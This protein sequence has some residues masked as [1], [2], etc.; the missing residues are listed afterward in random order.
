LRQLFIILAFIFPYSLLAQQDPQFSQYM[1]NPF[2]WNPSFSAL[3][4][5]Y[6][7]SAHH[8]SQWVGYSP[9]NSADKISPP[10]TQLFTF[11][12]PL[13]KMNSGAGFGLMNDNLGP[14]RN[15][16]ATFS[17]A[18][19]IRLGT[20]KL[21]G[22]LGIGVQSMYINTDLWRPENTNDPLL[23]PSGIENKINPNAKL[24]FGYATERLFVGFSVN[25]VIT[26]TFTFKSDR[27]KNRLERHYYLQASYQIL[28]SER[29][30]LQPSAIFKVV[31]NV[32]SAEFSSLIFLDNLWTGLAYRT[33]DALTMLVGTCIFPDK[34][35]KVGYNLDLS[36][37]NKSAKSLTSH[38]IFLSYNLASFL[39]N[40]KPIIRTPRFRY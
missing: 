28:L 13:K 9:S 15:L 37:I 21:V 24:G 35:L 8:R 30:T 36:V 7:L 20:G 3:K 39:D 38:E 25:N 10:S 23:A 6:T 29:V 14:V 17:Y 16:N 2:I 32:R 27:L 1:M 40:R 22:G 11:T 31:E 12:A 18:Y 34:S 26:P 5:D 19:G 4:D 33:S